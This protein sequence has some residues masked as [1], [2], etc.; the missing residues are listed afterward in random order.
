MA[1]SE[2]VSSKNFIS[3]SPENVVKSPVLT[4]QCSVGTEA[5]PIRTQVFSLDI[6][7]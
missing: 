1:K 4:L 7:I 3:K 5:T 2:A 6:V